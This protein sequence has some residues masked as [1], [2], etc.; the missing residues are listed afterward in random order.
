MRDIELTGFF[1]ATRAAASKPYRLDHLSE[2]RVEQVIL[3]VMPD[4]GVFYY[5][6]MGRTKLKYN[7]WR[8]G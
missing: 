5:D 4:P 6:P 2:A 7:S 1:P 8:L 3:P